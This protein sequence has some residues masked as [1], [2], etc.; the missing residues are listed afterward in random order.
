M[1]LGC[2]VWLHD[3]AHGDLAGRPRSPGPSAMASMRELVR[4]LQP[5]QHR[6]RQALLAARLA[7]RFRVGGLE[8]VALAPRAG[9]CADRPK[10]ASSLTLRVGDRSAFDA[11]RACRPICSTRA[12]SAGCFRLSFL[13][14]SWHMLSTL[15]SEI[16]RFAEGLQ[17]AT[18]CTETTEES[19]VSS[20]D[21]ADDRRWSGK[22]QQICVRGADDL[23]P[24]GPW[25]VRLLPFERR[26]H[27]SCEQPQVAEGYHTAGLRAPPLRASRRACE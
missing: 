11:V 23:A 2:I 15:L 18:E 24:G 12:L 14:V 7:G 13:Y 10:R 25:P 19:M 16:C 9:D 1:P 21:T 8:F 22:A 5:V 4:Q 26:Q 17:E 6:R 27:R 3:V 20:A